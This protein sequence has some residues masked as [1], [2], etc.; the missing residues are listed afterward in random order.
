[1]RP[2][3]DLGECSSKMARSNLL[4]LPITLFMVVICSFSK[5]KDMVLAPKSLH[6]SCTDV[7]HWEQLID[8]IDKN[9]GLKATYILTLMF[10]CTLEQVELDEEYIGL[11]TNRKMIIDPIYGHI[12]NN[13]CLSNAFRLK[14]G[15]NAKIFSV[16]MNRATG[17][18]IAEHMIRT[19]MV[20]PASCVM[21]WCA[22]LLLIIHRLRKD[23]KWV[24]ERRE[25]RI[26][27]K[28]MIHWLI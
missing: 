18:D 3:R 27:G 17:N 6:T 23:L 5:G 22:Q 12:L 21:A 7:T 1:M 4:L 8:F 19:G 15:H 25:R 14:L 20:I 10:K 9:R 28:R 26:V 11:Y 2:G 16:K 24:E 13:C